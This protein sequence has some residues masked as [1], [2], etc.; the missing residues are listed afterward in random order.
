MSRKEALHDRGDVPPVQM[1]S[2]DLTELEFSAVQ[3]VLRSKHLSLGP[4][5]E[6][7]ER[8]FAAYVGTRHAIA[9]SSGTAALHLSL[10]AAKVE[11]GDLVV[12]SPFSFVASANCALYERA[13]P[14]FVDV[15]PQTG[16]LDPALVR[17]AVRDLTDGRTSGRRWLPR[18]LRET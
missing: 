7:F 11:E 6:E 4:R 9:V 13:V 3:D 10:I 8:Q 18:G 5:L 12:T 16:N 14:L 17:E 1:S 15:D 2:P